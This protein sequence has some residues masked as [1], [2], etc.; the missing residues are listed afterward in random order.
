MA[1]SKSAY[2]NKQ[3]RDWLDRKVAESKNPDPVK[4]EKEKLKAKRKE[5]LKNFAIKYGL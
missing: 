2:T 3:L 4:L 5:R 1:D